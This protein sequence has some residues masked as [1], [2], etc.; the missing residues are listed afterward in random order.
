LQ[1]TF[2]PLPSL[3]VPDPDKILVVS[4]H[5]ND[6]EFLDLQNKLLMRHMKVPYDFVVGFDKPES[7]IHALGKT[8][9][10]RE[11]AAFANA[12][13]LPL[14][15]IPRSAHFQRNSIFFKSD[16]GD[17]YNPLDSAI[18]CADS[19]QYMLS[20]VPWQKYVALLVLD[21]DMFPIRDI[22][23]TP[24][25]RESPFLGIHQTR[26][27]KK[28]SIEYL[29]NGIFWLSGA[30]PFP[31]LIN[32]D[33]VLDKKLRT[34]VGGQTSVWLSSLASLGVTGKYMSHN[35]SGNWGRELANQAGLKAQLVQWLEADYRN[36]K[37]D[38]FFAEVYGDSFLHY[39]GGS[40]WMNQNPE[41][42]MANR[43]SLISA[44]LN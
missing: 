13:S 29:W 11:L 4:V 6:V 20:V 23:E 18:R 2:E 39:R 37:P 5:T 17:K 30:A 38:R 3:P 7:E 21:A 44:V 19:L 12:N 22:T 36:Q 42:D 1:T 27:H 24:V 31:H 40:N 32:F 25:T 26:N 14:V 33:L 16:L 41:V 10:P 35:A 43:A 9:T 8:D 28:R 34:D 15:L